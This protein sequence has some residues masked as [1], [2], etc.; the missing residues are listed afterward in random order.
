MQQQQSLSK[1]FADTQKSP[2]IKANAISTVVE[3]PTMPALRPTNIAVADGV[4]N[5]EP[6]A[7]ANDSGCYQN[8]ISASPMIPRPRIFA[9][10]KGAETGVIHSPAAAKPIPKL[11]SISEDMKLSPLDNRLQSQDDYCAYEALALGANCLSTDTHIQPSEKASIGPTSE[12]G[13]GFSAS[14]ETVDDASQVT[15]YLEPEQINKVNEKVRLFFVT[16]FI[17]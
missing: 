17:A 12:L 16:E 7:H 8:M 13:L 10:Q 9:P 3:Y 4:N 15:I 14:E 2:S 6:E 5:L 1:S 11:N